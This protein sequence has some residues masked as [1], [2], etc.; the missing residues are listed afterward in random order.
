MLEDSTPLQIADWV[1]LRPGALEPATAFP[2]YEAMSYTVVAIDR[3]R[4]TVDGVPITIT[5][6]SMGHRLTVDVGVLRRV[7]PAREHHR[8]AEDRA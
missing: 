7:D 1:K 2:H 3:A 4:E 5:Q 6:P 8:G